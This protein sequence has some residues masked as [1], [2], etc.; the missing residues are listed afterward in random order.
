MYFQADPNLISQIKP[1]APQQPSA[2]K[3]L[4]DK[5]ASI[6]A[7]QTAN[8]FAGQLGGFLTRDNQQNIKN[9]AGLGNLFSIWGAPYDAAKGDNRMA[10]FA[11]AVAG[12]TAG[13]SI[14][15][16][17][18]NQPQNKPATQPQP[19]PQPQQVAPTSTQQ[20]NTPVASTQSPTYVN[21]LAQMLMNYQEPSQL[22]FGEG[23]AGN[24][25]TATPVASQLNTVS[26]E[27]RR[28]QNLAMLLGP[29]AA[30][31]LYKHKAV[32]QNAEAAALNAAT[33]ASK[34][35]F[36]NMKDYA[37]YT[38]YMA[39]IDPVMQAKI[40]EA[41]KTGEM[42]GVRAHIEEAA[43]R[44]DTAIINN[45]LLNKMGFRTAGD[46]IRATQSTDPGVIEAAINYLA[47]VESAYISGTAGAKGAEYTVLKTLQDGALKDYSNASANLRALQATEILIPKDQASEARIEFE[48]K[49]QFYTDQMESAKLRLDGVSRILGEEVG[50]NTSNKPAQSSEQVL[51]NRT[52]IPKLVQGKDG[53]TYKVPPGYYYKFTTTGSVV[54]SKNANEKE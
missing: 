13:S 26:P 25:E 1:V 28:M 18:V 48:R 27:G 19:Q 37:T 40:E 21:S 16:D 36:E 38:K 15:G 9:L 2:V 31:D 22:P 44:A 45:P 6:P 52:N 53:K 30:M 41:K 14:A 24:A 34:A 50:L 49:R 47:R 3:L 35:P 10:Q 33:A 32:Q 29:S 12:M 39:E 46:I 23:V 4:I 8:K 42:A 5:L 11:N 7:V 51:R 43:K 54:I 20:P 17:E